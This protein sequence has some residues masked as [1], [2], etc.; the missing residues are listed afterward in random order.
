[1][2]LRKIARLW[3]TFAFALPTMRTHKGFA[4]RY[5]VEKMSELQ[6]GIEDRLRQVEKEVQS[7][8]GEREVTL[9]AVSKT[10][11]E[12][13]IEAA[14]SCGQRA[15]GE[16]YAQECCR[17]V[18]WFRE[19][20]PDLHLI[21]HFIGPLQ[22]NKTRPI[23]ERVDWVQ[24][25]DRLKIA[26]RLNDQR[27]ENLPPL[28][29]LIEVNI[30][31]EASKSGVAPADVAAL[32]REVAA[33]PRLKL[34]GLMTIPAPATTEEGKKKP[35]EDMAALYNSLKDEFGFDTLSMGMSADMLEAIAAGATMVRVGSAI[36]GHRTYPA[37]A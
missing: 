15:F 28:N 34:R 3:I 1:M 30:D 36:F 11:P 35:L 37:K 24:S 31:G 12:A 20:R 13:A 32:A 7:A 25:I 17:K 8:Q 33:L 23:A 4:C 9:L 27:P 5:E 2:I 16:N 21:W 10:F 18:D 22:A 14:A 29:V 19:N 6:P 26:Q